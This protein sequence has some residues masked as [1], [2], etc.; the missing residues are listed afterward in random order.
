MSSS[1]KLHLLCTFSVSLLTLLC[2]PIL[3]VRTKV[4]RQLSNHL[5]ILLLIFFQSPDSSGEMQIFPHEVI[6]WIQPLIQYTFGVSYL[7][8]NQQP[9]KKMGRASKML[10]A[11]NR[12]FLC[13]KETKING[14][15]LIKVDIWC[16]ILLHFNKSLSSLLILL[17]TTLSNMSFLHEAMISELDLCHKLHVL[18]YSFFYCYTKLLYLQ[19]P[20]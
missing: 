15:C 17:N 10:A 16:F 12:K 9:C 2:L 7:I 5:P 6:V 19:P 1:L 14:K 11:R 4:L 13:N 3:L 20:S 18:S 8:K